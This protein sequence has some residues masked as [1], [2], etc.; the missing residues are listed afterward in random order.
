MLTICSL[1]ENFFTCFNIALKPL[2][3]DNLF[4]ERSFFLSFNIS[5][6]LLSAIPFIAFYYNN[7]NVPPNLLCGPIYNLSTMKF[8]CPLTYA[9]VFS[10][11][12]LLSQSFTSLCNICAR[13]SFYT[14]SSASSIT[15]ST[16]QPY[17]A[18]RPELCCHPPLFHPPCFS[19]LGLT[20]IVRQ[21]TL[22]SKCGG[23]SMLPN[24]TI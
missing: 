14:N 7:S 23:E 17:L 22:C 3:P 19:V 16:K 5:L 10:N 13:A 18:Y 20:N 4:S 15:T 9:L 6:K 12:F 11:L 21:E 8:N 2:P 24:T 1:K